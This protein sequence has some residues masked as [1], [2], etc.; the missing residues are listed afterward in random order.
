MDFR[1]QI[2]QISSADYERILNN[3]QVI[4]QDKG[5]DR[6]RHISIEIKVIV[7]FGLGCFNNIKIVRDL[8]HKYLE[9]DEIQILSG[10]NFEHGN[11]M[12]YADNIEI[13]LKDMSEEQL[14]T[15]LK[16]F[17]VMVT[18]QDL[19]HLHNDKVFYLRD[20]LR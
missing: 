14:R 19:W 20:Y 10:G 17:K 12:E 9:N 6:F 5:I 7:P 3:E 18:W 8:L 4:S 13:Y 11:G 15:M 2:T 16:D 1:A